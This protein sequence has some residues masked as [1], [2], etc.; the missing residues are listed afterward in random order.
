MK[1]NVMFTSVSRPLLA[2][3]NFVLYVIGKFLCV[4]IYLAKSKVIPLYESVR[5]LMTS[6][7]WCVTPKLKCFF[8]KPYQMTCLW[9]TRW[10]AMFGNECSQTLLLLLNW[11][12]LK[13]DQNGGLSYGQHLN[14]IAPW[15]SRNR[16]IHRLVKY[17][18]LK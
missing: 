5:W 18:I 2:N 10:R 9:I 16:R 15:L 17:R 7:V 3:V 12:V 1:W 13:L 8:C 14:V 11:N 4:L 6:T